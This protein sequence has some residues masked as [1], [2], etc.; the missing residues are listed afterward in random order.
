LDVNSDGL[1]KLS[2][3]FVVEFVES[4]EFIEI[5]TKVPSMAGNKKYRSNGFCK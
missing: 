1:M 4:A 2:L 3:K 5:K